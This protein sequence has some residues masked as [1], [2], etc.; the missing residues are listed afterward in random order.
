MT[1]RQPNL[2]QT[3]GEKS[4]TFLFTGVLAVIVTGIAAPLGLFDWLPI[5]GKLFTRGGP[6]SGI[7]VLVIAFSLWVAL[8][9][10]VRLVTTNQ[11]RRAIRQ[12]RHVEVNASAAAL[13]P[14]ASSAT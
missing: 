9:V 1:N 8:F 13:A 6:V 3:T 12:L 11:E 4:R 14:S 5:I 7:A 2:R 10:L